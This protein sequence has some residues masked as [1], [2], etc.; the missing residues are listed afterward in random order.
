MAH[1]PSG[2]ITFLFTDIEGST[3]RWEEEREAMSGALARHDALMRRT[4]EAHGGHVFKTVGDAFCA[5]FPTPLSALEASEEAQRRL[6]REVGDIK[7]RMA[8][9]TGMAEERDGDYFGPTLNRVARLLSTGHGGQVLLSGPSYDLVRDYIPVP[10]S[11]RDLGEHRLKDLFRPERIYQLVAP[12]LPADFPPLKTLD[13]RPNNLPAQPTPLIGREK[14]AEAVVALLHRPDA[15]LVTLTGPGGTGKTRLALQVAADTLDDFPDGVWFVNLAPITDPTLVA[16]S[17]AQALGVRET[18]GQPLVDSLKAYLGE[19]RLLLLLDNFE[20][21]VSASPLVAD[22]VAAAPGLKVLVTSREPLHLRGEKEYAVPP[23]GLPDLRDRAHPPSPE[24]LAQYEAV[25]LFIERATDVKPDF[26]I[27]NDNAPA[28]AEICYRLDGL[29]LA[30]ELA[31][32]RIRLLPPQAMLER[33][34]SRLKLLT[35]GARDLP[36]RQQTLRNTIEWSYELLDDDE[37]RL[38]RRLAVFQGGRTLEAIEAVCN[39]EGDLGIDVLEGVESLISKSLLQQREGAEGEPRFVMLETIHEYAREKLEETW[40]VEGLRH[41]RA[42][43]FMALAEVAEPQ[44]R[45]PQ[46]LEWLNRLEEEQDNFRAA[47]AW[48]QSAIVKGMLSGEVEPVDIGLRLVG[49]LNRFWLYRSHYSEGREHAESIL[50]LDAAKV[51]SA[52]RQAALARVLLVEGLLALR[53]D[54]RATFRVRGEEALAIFRGLGD[55]HGIASAL[56]SLAVTKEPQER[57]PLLEESRAIFKEEGDAWNLAR[58]LYQFGGQAFNQGSYD[59][60]R[61]FLNEG[62]ALME[63]TGDKAG[64]TLFLMDLGNIASGLGDYASAR[65]YWEKSLAL[66]RELGD[67]WGTAVALVNLVDV[68][69]M[70]GNPTSMRPLAEEA[71]AISVEIRYVTHAALSLL[72]L[73]RMALLEGEIDRARALLQESLNVMRELPP[74]DRAEEARVL[75]FLGHLAKREGDQDSAAELYSQSL[76]VRQEGYKLWDEKLVVANTLASLAGLGKAEVAES[77]SQTSKRAARLFGAAQA[78]IEGSIQ[79]LDYDEQIEFERNLTVARARL[80][81]AA[82]QKAWAEGRAMTIEQAIAYALSDPDSDLTNTSL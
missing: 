1:L 19:K 35:G 9:H 43:Y 36:T 48:I 37:K 13:A 7:V 77:S 82:W 6:Q 66:C 22:L 60:A 61:E 79:P 55:K 42:L 38:F 63:Q 41:A 24:S 31:A 71:L 64:S 74:E 14:E 59:R 18:G 20:Q 58:V 27:T 81:E 29:P 62:L 32:A 4:I 28:V 80:D 54:D 17:I 26:R 8:L 72:D 50:K 15:R 57:T 65:S 12:D 40:E 73:G 69:W 56:L 70:L 30:I 75:R 33:L 68:A 3:R 23:L 11:V 52:A 51:G 76:S 46:Q 44:V 10:A 16:S 2:T 49:A 67:K 45:G 53:Q 39:A 78:L 5:A 34:Q 25:R 47:L 21:V